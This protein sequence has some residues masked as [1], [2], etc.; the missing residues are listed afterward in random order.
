MNNKNS[1]GG[2]KKGYIPWN[3]GKKGLCVSWLKGKHLTKEVKLKIS[4]SMKSKNIVIPRTAEGEKKRISSLP[5]GKNHWNWKGGMTHSERSKRWVDKNRSKKYFMTLRRRARKNNAEGSH[6]FED[7]LLLKS[8]YKNMC[9]CC[10][11]Q[12]PVIELTQDHIVPLSMGGSDYIDNIQPLCRSCNSIK[13]V[14]TINYRTD[15]NQ[16]QTFLE[17]INF[18]GV[19]I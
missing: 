11:K 5:K 2:F 13:K 4:L 10:K 18:Q 6:T 12:E 14:K 3:K 19:G 17:D 15:L 16:V 7:W 1:K 9:L 8:Y